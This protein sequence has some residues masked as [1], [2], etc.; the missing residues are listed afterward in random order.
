ML[1]MCLLTS[2]LSR[3]PLQGKYREM[4]GLKRDTQREGR[5][6]YW[7]TGPRRDWVPLWIPGGGSGNLGQRAS[8]VAKHRLMLWG[9]FQQHGSLLEFHLSVT[10]TRMRLLLRLHFSVNFHFLPA[11]QGWCAC[12]G[13]RSVC[14]ATELSPCETD[15]YSW[16]L[17]SRCPRVRLWF[18]PD[19]RLRG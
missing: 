12:L 9:Q 7:V 2:G 17:S 15:T 8:F 6:C 5:Q 18:P 3:S 11:A 16:A 13:N 14:L 19:P 4:A 1:N 10:Q